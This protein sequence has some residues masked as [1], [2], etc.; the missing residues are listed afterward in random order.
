MVKDSILRTDGTQKHF[1]HV[2]AASQEAWNGAGLNKV[3]GSLKLGESR[4]VIPDISGPEFLIIYP[5][6]A[7]Q[8]I[9]KMS[10]GERAS[11]G[12]FCFLH[13]GMLTASKR[14]VDRKGR[15]FSVHL[16]LGGIPPKD[17][18]PGG[19]PL[20]TS[21]QRKL[22]GAKLS[23]RGWHLHTPGINQGV[24]LE[25]VTKALRYFE[26]ARGTGSNLKLM[27]PTY[28]YI[29]ST[30]PNMKLLNMAE[31]REAANAL[32]RIGENFARVF[33][34]MQREFFPR[35]KLEVIL[36]HSPK[37]RSELNRF[38]RQHPKV[39]KMET[40]AADGFIIGMT[41]EQRKALRRLWAKESLEYK[42]LFS[43]I[44]ASRQ[45]TVFMLHG[46]DVDGYPLEGIQVA[47]K[48]VGARNLKRNIL[49][50]GVPG[51]PAVAIRDAWPHLRT[52]AFGKDSRKLGGRDKGLPIDIDA[53]ADGYFARRGEKVTSKHLPKYVGKGMQKGQGECPSFS[54]V[55]TVGPYVGVTEGPHKVRQAAGRCFANSSHQQCTDLFKTTHSRLKRKLHP[56]KKKVRR[57]QHRR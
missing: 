12:G 26:I 39:M 54:Y 33:Y 6:N 3:F 50:L 40:G 56:A 8:V 19:K 9:P 45:P 43:W 10:K 52:G 49:F 20:P 7:Q 5:E 37:F 25:V 41:S 29:S 11:I 13:Q 51:A 17:V 42:K 22:N 55:R 30:I 24:P 27:I 57:V 32:K 16:D 48:I 23:N 2:Y 38:A 36:T 28:E 35:V 15:R 34:R 46:R 4:K 21:L 1:K 47:E 53:R 14:V 31:E 44:F 18:F